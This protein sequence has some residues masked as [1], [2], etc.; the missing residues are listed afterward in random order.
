MTSKALTAPS[1]FSQNSDGVFV[2]ND[3]ARG[4]WSADHCHAGPVTGLAA[5]AAEIEIGAEKMLCRMTLDILR[6]LPLSGLRVAAET[7]RH[8]RTLATTQITVHD[9]DN[10]LCALG[11]TMHLVRK[12]LGDVPTAAVVPLDRAKAVPGP[13][14]IGAGL[15]DKPYFGQFLDVAYPP[16]FGLHPGPKTLWM[17]TPNLLEGEQQSP[18]QSLCALADCGNGISWNAHPKEMGFMNT[19]LTLNVH[20][21]PQGDWHAS[22]S[23]S[24][25]HSTGIG[26]SQSVLQDEDGPVATALQTL[27]LHPPKV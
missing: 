22:E 9:L 7:T 15:H 4:P 12:D 26:M 10:S 11:T 2:G 20:R 23:I 5:R 16:E 17:R 24:H 8:T 25:W 27:V 19:D 13:F 3:P 21:E 18:I 14:S 6:P 1:F